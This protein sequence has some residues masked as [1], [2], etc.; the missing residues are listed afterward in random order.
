ML[1]HPRALDI[2][3]SPVLLGVQYV[4]VVVKGARTTYTPLAA[5]NIRRGAPLVSH[6][7]VVEEQSTKRTARRGHTGT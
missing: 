7:V 1:D 3:S 2:E 6:V 5:A 4:T